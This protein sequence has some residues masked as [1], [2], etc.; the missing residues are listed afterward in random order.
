MKKFIYSLVLLFSA[1]SF[2]SGSIKC[3]LVKGTFHKSATV[4]LKSGTKLT[5][6][7]IYLDVVDSRGGGSAGYTRC[8]AYPYKPE[9]LT[10]YDVHQCAYYYQ[11]YFEGY[12]YFT[13][14][15][16]TMELRYLKADN[17]KLTKAGFDSPFGIFS[18]K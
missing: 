15:R 18:C 2:A 13:I 8:E 9:F 6:Q 10:G 16:S 14:K 3:S 1:S 7:M 4:F 11:G 5:P 17:D 12:S